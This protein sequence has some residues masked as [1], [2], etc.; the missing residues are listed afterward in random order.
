MAF[1]TGRLSGDAPRDVAEYT[2]SL[3]FDREIYREV[4]LINAV[5][6]KSL[7]RMGYLSPDALARGLAALKEAYDKPLSLDDPRLEDVHMVVEGYLVTV[8]PEAG[9][10]LALGKSR[11]DSVATAIRMRAKAR[12]LE[13]ADSALNLASRLLERSFEE[14]ETIYPATTHLQVAAPATLGFILSS[15]AS[16]LLYS[17]ESLIGVYASLD[18]CPQGSAACCGSTLPMDR[19]WLASQLGF[20][21]VLEHSLDA[22]S[23]RD[24]VIDL[25]SLSL[26]L[27]VIASDIA[28]WL[29]HDL[30]AGL[31]DIGD[32]FCSTSSIMPQ[33]RNPV[34]LEV[35]RTK[36]S[37]AL[38]EAVRA[39]SIIQRRVG[40]YVL[41][42]QQVT[43][44]IWRSLK[45][46]CSALEMLARVVETLRVD[47][48]AA[49]E[50]CGLLA[51]MVEL[52][53]YLTLQ[54][55]VG[56]RRAHRACGRLARMLVEKRL[57]EEGLREALQAE[58]IDVALGLEEVYRVLDPRSIVAS[59][60]TRGSASPGEVRRMTDA[61]RRRMAELREWV[62][63]NRRVLEGIVKRAFNPQVM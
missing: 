5:H 26:K 44:S 51:G 40:G 63:E 2:S 39:S 16:R 20:T 4:L 24:F 13:L 33:K 47:V 11:N 61:M 57:T 7:A 23:S 54:H 62:S 25:L 42:L 56:F 28:E 19:G 18:Y 43:P 30:T 8:V 17:L 46:A 22:S 15:Y 27:L 1:R 10:N 21:H 48:D 9:E 55:G 32:E 31:L 6:L 37:E 3:G 58:G 35:I 50:R 12:M 36:A 59:Y 41:D 14:A 53:N 34:V 45:E 60:A 29:I 49:L 38:G 52:A